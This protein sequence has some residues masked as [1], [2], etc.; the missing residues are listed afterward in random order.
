MA[1]FGHSQ[2]LLGV[3]ATILALLILADRSNLIYSRLKR[4]TADSRKRIAELRALVAG[5]VESIKISDEYQELEDKHLKASDPMEV[6][7]TLSL[8]DEFVNKVS[9][10]VLTP[11]ANELN[12]ILKSPEIV[13]A[14]L[15][16][17]LWIILLFIG[18]LLC[19][20][21]KDLSFAVFMFDSA[22][23]LMSVVYW[24][25]IWKEFS[26]REKID[27]IDSINVI[28]PF[29]S[30]RRHIHE[31]AI[32]FALSVFDTVFCV[33]AAALV[34]HLPYLIEWV[35]WLSAPF[36]AFICIGNN[37]IIYKK[38][39]PN[40][41]YRSLLIH[42]AAIT[43]CAL[44]YILILYIPLSGIEDLH[45]VPQETHI[46]ILN[47]I[48]IL[49][50]ILFGIVY[51]FLKPYNRWKKKD[52]DILKALEEKKTEALSLKEEFTV[53]AIGHLQA[54]R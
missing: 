16:M 37:R 35:V 25:I 10:S 39:Y 6:L 26:K 54:L 17:L 41:T 32:L 31:I 44:G 46:A 43:I 9:E 19:S 24:W 20:T 11:H 7:D 2:G 1:V 34:H 28:L 5:V 15:Y 51:P 21:W 33:R 29:R 42:F 50:I 8:P 36:L 53:K 40:S 13:H 47:L 12:A 52:K 49:A 4:Y 14:P 38:I 30:Y 27:T 3:L 18:D 45:V 23:M 48:T 22:F